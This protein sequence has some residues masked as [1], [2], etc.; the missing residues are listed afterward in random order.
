MQNRIIGRIWST[1]ASFLPLPVSLSRS[2]NFVYLVNHALGDRLLVSKTDS[3]L[4]Q[5][6]I[7][8]ES[9]TTPTSTEGV[10]IGDAGQWRFPTRDE[11]QWGLRVIVSHDKVGTNPLVLSL[12]LS[13]SFSPTPLSFP[14][15]IVYGQ[16]VVVG[17]LH[18]AVTA[19]VVIHV[20]HFNF[21][22]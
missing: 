15:I 14:N 4:R 20:Y 12:S 5:L 19:H 8:S 7:T 21:Y 1:L 10:A 3:D 17:R 16:V 11:Q 13:H 18:S 22:A 2:S 6:P 9:V